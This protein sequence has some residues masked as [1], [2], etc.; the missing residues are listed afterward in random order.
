MAGAQ[1]HLVRVRVRLGSAL[2]RCLFVFDRFLLSVHCVVQ[3]IETGSVEQCLSGITWL[4]V[5]ARLV[6]SVLLSSWNF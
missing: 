2:V 6:M 4:H 1:W 3:A 5:G